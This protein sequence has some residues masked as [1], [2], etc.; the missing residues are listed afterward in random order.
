MGGSSPAQAAIRT[1]A[2]PHR[3]WSAQLHTGVTPGA[4]QPTSTWALPPG[5]LMPL[6]WDVAC[7]SLEAPQVALRC[8]P[9]WE[10][11]TRAPFVNTCHS[12]LAFCLV[13]FV[14]AAV[15]SV[16]SRTRTAVCLQ[17]EERPDRHNAAS[18]SKRQ[19]LGRGL[20]GVFTGASPAAGT[21][22]STE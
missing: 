2:P 3:P 1:P 12:A 20:S 19:A 8:S 14:V 5:T 11:L 17:A 15:A 22:P 4:R 16:T 9:S 10:A 7:A 6:V 13:R 18:P 21:V